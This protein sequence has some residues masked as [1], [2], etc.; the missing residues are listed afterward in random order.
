ME[1]RPVVA[2]HTLGCKLNQAETEQLAAQFARA[3]YC[4]ASGDGADICILN[5]CTVTHIADRKSRHLLRLLR[6]Q[7]PN[8]LIV[9]TG[10]YAQRA[11]GELDQT[12]SDLVIG[13]EQKMD[14]LALVNGKLTLK[15]G[16]PAEGYTVD[17]AS[18]VRSFIRIQDGCDDFCAYCVVP[19]VRGPEHCL[20]TAAIIEIVKARVSAGYREVI[21]TGTKIGTYNNSGID[22]QRLLEHILSETDVQ[23]LHLSS[24]QPQE[25]SGDLL[26]MWQDSRLCRHFHL[27]LQSGSDAVLK[28]MKRRYTLD[29]YKQAVSLIHRAVPGAAITTDV[30]VGF[31]GE[32]DGEF[33]ESYR[34]CR[35]TG[36]AAIHVFSYSARPGTAA[37]EMMGQVADKVKKQRSLRMLALAR[38]SVRSFQE[39]SLGQTLKVLWENEAGPGTGIYSGLS[40]NYIRVFA[41]S[42]QTLTNTIVP[43][44]PVR[45]YKGGLWAEVIT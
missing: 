22:L 12:G 9:A 26:S 17:G 36:F 45:P 15:P 5:T 6:K 43:V 1:N 42:S 8:A 32:S 21:L 25:V 23:R 2:F 14:L 31:P 18:R 39:R 20:S 11:P 7:N 29:D 16:C 4:I 28:R 33:E 41:R 10:C 44:R 40:D 37:A 3:G 34:F 38:E 13:N 30:V 24:L 27:A 19:L 35:D